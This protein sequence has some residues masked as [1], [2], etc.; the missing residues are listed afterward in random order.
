MLGLRVSQSRKEISPHYLFE[1]SAEGPEEKVHFSPSGK[2]REDFVKDT[3][4]ELTPE[5][6]VR[7]PTWERAL[8]RRYVYLKTTCSPVLLEHNGKGGWNGRI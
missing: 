6:R 4:S 3:T 7:P 8:Q 2:I 5:K 1:Q